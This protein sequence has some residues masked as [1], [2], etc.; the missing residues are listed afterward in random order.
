MKIQQDLRY[1]YSYYQ[2]NQWRCYTGNMYSIFQGKKKTLVQPGKAVLQAA[3]PRGASRNTPIADSLSK[4]SLFSRRN[5]LVF[6]PINETMVTYN[7][8]ISKIFLRKHDRRHWERQIR[9]PC[10]SHHCPHRP[11]LRLRDCVFKRHFHPNFSR[12][13]ILNK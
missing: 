3:S 10:I 7:Q 5:A 1:Y 4:W 12:L 13:S 11:S 6:D 8:L 9:W 2:S